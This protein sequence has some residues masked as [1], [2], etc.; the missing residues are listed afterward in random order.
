[1]EPRSPIETKDRGEYAVEE[2]PPALEGLEGIDRESEQITH[3]LRGAISAG[4]L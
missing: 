4:S 2:V 3:V 1:M